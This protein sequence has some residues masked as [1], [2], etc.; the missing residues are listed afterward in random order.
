ML[1]CSWCILWT[2]KKK[3][4]KIFPYRCNIPFIFHSPIVWLCFPYNLIHRVHLTCAHRCSHIINMSNNICISSL[5]S[6]SERCSRFAVSLRMHSIHFNY[7]FSGS[8]DSNSICSKT[9]FILI[10]HV[11]SRTMMTMM[12]MWHTI[13]IP[14]TIIATTT[15]ITTTP[16]TI[17]AIITLVTIA[18]N[19]NPSLEANQKNRTERSMVSV[20]VNILIT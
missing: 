20:N 11:F 15:T 2:W 14:T 18:V 7:L 10:P 17:T 1:M 16:T 8:V 4:E 6:S 13:A 9:Q 19:W 3:C 5:W 12:R